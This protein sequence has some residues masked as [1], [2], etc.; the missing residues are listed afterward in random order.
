M[1][2]IIDY[3]K[4]ERIATESLRSAIET[5]VSLNAV[6]AFALCVD[7]D[8][9]SGYLTVFKAGDALS[10][11][12]QPVNWAGLPSEYLE[13]TCSYLSER[14][15]KQWDDEYCDHYEANVEKSFLSLVEA[16]ETVKV[17]LFD[18]QVLAVICGSDPSA[19]MKVMQTNA[20]KHLNSKAV[21]SNWGAL[22]V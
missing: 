9:S 14:T 6:K 16:I 8:V 12:N 20:L 3:S 10:V 21:L 22:V 7:D 11:A 13:P 17:G 1:V 18:E 15:E 2:D 19:Q 4:L 5:S